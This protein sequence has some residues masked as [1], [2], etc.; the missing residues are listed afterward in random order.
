MVEVAG[1]FNT[2]VG[3]VRVVSVQGP[4]NLKFDLPGG[5]VVNPT[6]VP[7]R[8]TTAQLATAELA[9]GNPQAG[10]PVA[11]QVGVVYTEIAGLAGVGLLSI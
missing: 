6:A 3:S 2:T 5:L 11:S 10:C 9:T 4:R 1:E 7:V 8:C